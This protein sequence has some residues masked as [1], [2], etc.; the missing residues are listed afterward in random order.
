M[1]LY[2]ISFANLILQKYADGDN[3][4]WAIEY[5]EN[6][7]MIGTINFV[8]LKEKYDWRCQNQEIASRF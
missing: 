6:R 3:H 4:F 2:V 5:K 8:H 7:K 1:L